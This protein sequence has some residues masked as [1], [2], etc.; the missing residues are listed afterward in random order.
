MACTW[1]HGGVETVVEGS[2]AD[3]EMGGQGRAASVG[4]H[5]FPGGGDTAGNVEHV[6][7]VRRGGADRLGERIF[8]ECV[9]TLPFQHPQPRHEQDGQ[10]HSVGYPELAGI[11]HRFHLM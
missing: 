3:G 4:C 9:G 8:E 6:R 11:W 7:A 10:A 1:A 5:A 2:G